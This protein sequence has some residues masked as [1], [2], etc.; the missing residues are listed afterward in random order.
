MTTIRFAKTTLLAALCAGAAVMPATAWGRSDE[1]ATGGSAAAPTGASGPTSA[2]GDSAAADS[3][4]GYSIGVAT[5][6]GPGLYGRRTA[7]GTTLTPTTI[8]VAH[9]TLPCGTRLEVHFGGRRLVVPVI[10]R[11][12]FV[13]GITWDLT[14]QAARLLSFPGRAT[15]GTVPLG[16]GAVPP[17]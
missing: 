7:C 15:V 5:F 8:G 11:G 10:D 4:A 1:P 12:P 14:A 16:R 2:R 3:P 6:Y 17:A 13:A 9:R